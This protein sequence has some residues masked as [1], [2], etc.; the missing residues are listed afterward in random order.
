MRPF[1][2]PRIAVFALALRLLA[3]LTTVAFADTVLFADQPGPR[4]DQS[5]I[6]SYDPTQRGSAN[7]GPYD[8]PDFVVLESQI[9]G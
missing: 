2:L 5:Q 6:N 8:S 1:S 7:V 4:L 3:A 9:H